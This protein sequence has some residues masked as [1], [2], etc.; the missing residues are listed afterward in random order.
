MLNGCTRTDYVSLFAYQ[1]FH[2]V[3]FSSPLVNM[4]LKQ[5]QWT[6]PGWEPT[7]VIINGF[8]IKDKLQDLMGLG[9]TNYRSV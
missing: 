1:S 3:S 7:E 9:S 8:F 4:L 5:I 2:P 6:G